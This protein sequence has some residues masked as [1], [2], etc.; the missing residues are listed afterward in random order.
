MMPTGTM[1]PHWT[2][3]P[4]RP[5]APPAWYPD[6]TGAAQLRYFDGWR[7]TAHVAAYPPTAASG[8][9]ALER[10]VARMR[11]IDA[12][13]FGWRPVAVPILA[14]VLVIAASFVLDDVID[15]R[16]YAARV[17]YVIIANAAAEGVL[18]AAV[19][20]AGRE[21]AARYGGWGVA[22]GWRRPRWMDLVWALCGFGAA[23]VLRIIVGVIAALLS[24][25]H[26][27]KEAQNLTLTSVTALA[28]VILAVLTVICAP[29][30]EELVFRGL[31]LRT[32]MRRWGFWP[33]AVLSTA[34]F[35]VFHT[36]EVNTL[37]GAVTLAFGVATLG[38]TNCFINRYTDRLAPG[39]GAHAL[40]N[41]L[42]LL[43]LVLTV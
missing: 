43:F 11:E 18:V 31:L 16:S 34:I 38:I 9:P 30:I 25:G 42:A 39:I 21:V 12:R 22:F 27:V 29:L 15:P 3:R 28:V 23:F 35:A 32:F 14:F 1:P 5:A 33:A 20:Y 26:A 6:P 19:W 40:S 36:Y 8:P 10:S 37:A 7:W 24:H 13:P 4:G 17:A 2:Q 41:G